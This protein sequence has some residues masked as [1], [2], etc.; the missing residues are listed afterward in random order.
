MSRGAGFIVLAA[1]DVRTQLLFVLS[2]RKLTF[3]TERDVHVPPIVS[4]PFRC[5]LVNLYLYTCNAYHDPQSLFVNRFHFPKY[6][7]SLVVDVTPVYIYIYVCVCIRIGV[8]RYI[9][10]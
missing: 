5:E 1:S 7:V 4:F 8:Y 6:H 10:L 2:I 3:G 9:T